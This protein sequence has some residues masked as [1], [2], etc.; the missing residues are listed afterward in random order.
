[1]IGD[2]Y[3]WQHNRFRSFGSSEGLPFVLTDARLDVLF[4]IRQ[5]GKKGYRWKLKTMRM[6]QEAGLV[7]EEVQINRA[8]FLFS[9][10]FLTQKGKDLLQKWEAAF[11]S[12]HDDTEQ[13]A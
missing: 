11:G 13:S 9:A 3:N 10:F 1:M 6:F 7:V 12:R 5:W 8:G 2:R 4:E